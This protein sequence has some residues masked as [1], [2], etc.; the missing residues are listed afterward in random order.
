MRCPRIKQDSFSWMTMNQ[1][2]NMEIRLSLGNDVQNMTWLCFF[3]VVVN[4]FYKKANIS[5]F[6]SPLKT[7]SESAGIPRSVLQQVDNKRETFWAA[8]VLLLTGLSS[9]WFIQCV[10][11]T[12]RSTETLFYWKMCLLIADT[13]YVLLS[14]MKVY[15]DIILFSKRR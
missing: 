1:N 10:Q 6:V 9:S 5:H 13:E 12:D 15:A 4:S 7:F 2:Q 14:T 3:T 8:C 11:K